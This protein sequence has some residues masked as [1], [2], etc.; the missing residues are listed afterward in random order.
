MKEDSPRNDD[1]KPEAAT[2]TGS[3]SNPIFNPTQTQQWKM[4]DLEP[5]VDKTIETV[6]DN[7]AAT[8]EPGA[9]KD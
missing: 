5:E 3:E 7:M 6:E 4:T 2:P 1:P 8:I 9:Q